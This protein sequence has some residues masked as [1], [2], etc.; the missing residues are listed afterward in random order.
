MDNLLEL[1]IKIN[2]YKS[3]VLL[4]F[5][6]DESNASEESEIDDSERSQSESS[7]K[8]KSGKKIA[9]TYRISKSNRRS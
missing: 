3:R 4:L 2:D 5:E 1:E 7:S 9:Q 8:S 6:N